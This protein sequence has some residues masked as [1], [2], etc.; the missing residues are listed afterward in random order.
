[1]CSFVSI[2]KKKLSDIRES[3]IL[4]VIFN[5][6]MVK[7]GDEISFVINYRGMSSNTITKNI[8]DKK[9][10]SDDFK[11]FFENYVKSHG[12]LSIDVIDVLFFS[13][14]TPEMEQSSKAL[15]QPYRRVHNNEIQNIV[16]HGTIP[17]AEKIAE[18][19]GF[20]IEVDTE[21][22]AHMD[23]KEACMEVEKVGGK[24]SALKSSNNL[25]EPE[26]YHNGLG[27]FKYN[28][29]FGDD[30]MDFITNINLHN[31]FK[32]SKIFELQHFDIS[33]VT[34]FPNATPANTDVRVIALFSGGLDI[35]CSVQKT[36]LENINHV[37]ELDLWYFDWGTVANTPE[38][39]AGKKFKKLMNHKYDF[40]VNYKVIPI[41]PLFANILQA[42]DMTSTRL[43]D[44]DSKGA[45]SHEAEA[46]ISYVPYRNTIL[47]TLAAARAEQ[48]Y[49]NETIKFVIGANLSEGMIY[50]D[51]SESWVD[52]MD[53]ILKV[54][55]QQCANFNISA[56][57]VNRTKT[58]MI[59]DS[60]K[61]DF[62]FDTA[63][64]CY[65]PV[66]G[67][68]CGKC[69]SCLLKENAIQRG[70]I[71]RNVDGF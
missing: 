34:I 37:S 63:F 36:L 55:G 16:V 24:I 19:Y 70:Q 47:L 43:T 54:G 14:L 20:D 62:D 1:M 41:K 18:K 66:N 51:N 13:R 7:G 4:Y 32:N 5:A 42:C 56:P 64:S 46:A 38:I 26:V 15:S 28:C 2:K 68:A 9:F 39:K 57:Y 17:E 8:M 53:S 65:F 69:G 40:N 22:F 30:A 21:I 71:K 11:N 27:A 33:I 50:L 6:L 59:K 12:M 52:G 23:F 48:L 49:P 58:E 67:K 35:T 10:S 31:G 45:G 25:Y 61:L 29:A 44:N 3:R 60:I